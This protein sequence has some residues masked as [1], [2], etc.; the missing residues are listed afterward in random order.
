LAA[1]GRRSA[2]TGPVEARHSRNTGSNLCM[3]MPH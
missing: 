2:I 3:R 1:S